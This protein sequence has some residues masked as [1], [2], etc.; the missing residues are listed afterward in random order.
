ML[1]TAYALAEK[2]ALRDNSGGQ[3]ELTTAWMADYETAKNAG[4][5]LGTYA[6]EHTTYAGTE[7]LKGTNGK[8]ISNSRG[9]LYMQKVYESGKYTQKQAQTLFECFGLG[10]SIRDLTEKEVEAALEKCYAKQ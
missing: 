7:S 1:E 4:I 2:I 10:T 8:T 9:L 5:G 6:M 3:Y